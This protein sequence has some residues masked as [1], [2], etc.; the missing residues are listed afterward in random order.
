MGRP[1]KTK[2][3]VESPVEGKENTGK[4]TGAVRKRGRP[5]KVITPV[6]GEETTGEVTKGSPAAGGREVTPVQEEEG[7]GMVEEENTEVTGAVRKRG[8]PREVITPGE[9]VEATGKTPV[10]SST[11]YHQGVP[12]PPPNVEGVLMGPRLATR[13]NISSVEE[14]E[15]TGV[16]KEM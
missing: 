9:G 7:I 16:V 15:N 2:V 1:R 4:V 6:E 12:F 13:I 10:F 14:E 8:R 3:E 5:R 11:T